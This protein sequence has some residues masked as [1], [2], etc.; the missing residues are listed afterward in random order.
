MLLLVGLGNPG[1]KYAN[2]RHNIGFMAVDEIVRRHGFGPWCSKFQ[3]LISEG[4]LAGRKVMIAKPATF[5]N[6]SGRALA[7]I[8]RFYKLDLDDVIVI[9]DEIDLPP[10]KMRLKSGGGHGGNN[11]LRSV[12]RHIGNDFRRVRI[13]VGHP[14]RK[15]LVAR[16]VLHDFAKSDRQWIEPLIDAI[17]DNIGLLAAGKDASFGNKVHLT[18][19]PQKPERPKKPKK[20][21]DPADRA[22]E[23]PATEDAAPSDGAKGPMAALARLFGTGKE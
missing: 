14:G 10:G 17:A 19:N 18:L 23:K 11:G 6:E 4:T 21:K 1:P 2:N 3:A 8:I 9:H 20:P 5:M 7:E 13:G 16:Y 22:S 15:D 12:C